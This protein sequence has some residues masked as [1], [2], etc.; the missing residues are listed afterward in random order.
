MVEF[1]P[2]PGDRLAQPKDHPWAEHSSKR[3][4]TGEVN[5]MVY[6]ID[7]RKTKLCLRLIKARNIKAA[8][9]GGTSDA[10]IKVR[11]CRLTLG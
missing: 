10:Y 8:D 1:L 6:F 11:R 4:V 7:R 2:L 5:V 9:L 3:N